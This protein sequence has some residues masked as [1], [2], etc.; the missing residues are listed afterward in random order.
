MSGVSGAYGGIVSGIQ[1]AA[2]AAL[3]MV[4]PDVSRS[5][6]FGGSA[7]LMGIQYPYLVLTIPRMCTPGRQNTYLGY[8]SFVTAALSSVVGFASV[9]IT[10]L[11]G[12]SATDE[13]VS[14]IIG[15]L[16]EGVIF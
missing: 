4:K 11:E 15:L 10:H 13:E 7:G 6:S 1:D 16:E 5:G 2:N 12:M 8:P 9:E 14:E 3:S